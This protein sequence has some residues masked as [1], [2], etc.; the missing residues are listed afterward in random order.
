MADVLKA[1]GMVIAATYSN[2]TVY[3]FA[4]AKNST[5]SITRDSIELAPKTNSISREFLPGR[6]SFTVSGS[7]LIKLAQNYMHGLYFFEPFMLGSDAKFKCYLDMIDNQNNYNVYKFDCFFTD[8]TLESTYGSTPS[9][10]YTLQGA[11]PIELINIVDT[12]T[13]ASSKITGL[14]T[15]LYKLVALGYGGKWYFNYTV[16]EPSTG[17]FEIDMTGVPNGTVVKAAYIAI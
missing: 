9:Y 5:V 12:K 6:S 10:S 7:G 11:G 2:G 3:P 4:C 8:L 14:N 1:E 17:V 15:A 16:T 13:V